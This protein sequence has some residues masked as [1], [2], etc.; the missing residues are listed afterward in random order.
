MVKF[1][2]VYA[3]QTIRD[4]ALLTAAIRKRRVKALLGV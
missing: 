4:H 2:F 3:D 1:A